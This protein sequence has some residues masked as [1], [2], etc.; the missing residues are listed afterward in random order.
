[1]TRSVLLVESSLVFTAFT[2]TEERIES[3]KRG[4]ATK[5]HDYIIVIGLAGRTTGTE[6]WTIKR[7]TTRL[8]RVCLRIM[9]M[10]EK[11]VDIGSTYA[12]KYPS[13]GTGAHGIYQ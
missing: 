6:G 10:V 9:T 12:L 13:M 4:V 7:V 2:T 5:R 3:G 8:S 11:T 1:M